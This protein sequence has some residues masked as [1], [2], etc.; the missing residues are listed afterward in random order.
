MKQAADHA[1]ARGAKQLWIGEVW[2]E[3][4]AGWKTKTIFIGQIGKVGIGRWG[5]WGGVGMW[6]QWQLGPEGG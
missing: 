4:Q 1:Q 2:A 5:L 6:M 3:L